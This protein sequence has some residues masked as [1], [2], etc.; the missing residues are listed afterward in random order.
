MLFASSDVTAESVSA[1]TLYSGSLSLLRR[2]CLKY[3]SGVECRISSSFVLF[4]NLFILRK[5]QDLFAI[6]DDLF[7]DV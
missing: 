1:E 2:S 7:G 4:I 3:A 6:N 5:Y